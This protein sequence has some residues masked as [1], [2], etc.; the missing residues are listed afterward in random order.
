MSHGP[1]HE[2][3]RANAERRLAERRL[4]VRTFAESSVRFL[5][6]GTS[7]GDVLRGE[8]LDASASGIGV[9]F[10]ESLQVEEK[11]LLEV[12]DDDVHCF[13]LTEKVVWCDERDDGLH[14][15]GCELCVG[16]TDRQYEMLQAI[17]G[18]KG[19]K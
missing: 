1:G 4:N 9:V 19:S 11:L 2:P 16:L 17:A 5:R 8:L 14:V 12:Q 7:A 18:R 6:S 10:E 15:V 13:N 3:R